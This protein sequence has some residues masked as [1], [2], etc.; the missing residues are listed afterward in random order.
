[1]DVKTPS[2]NQPLFDVFV[3]QFF[4]KV[5][6]APTLENTRSFDI[7]VAPYLPAN[8]HAT[9]LEIGVGMGHFSFYATKVRGYTNFFGV[10]VSGECVAY[11]KE[12]ITPKVE[13]TED[14]EVFLRAHPQAYDAIV[15]LDVIEHIEK[16]RQRAHLEAIHQAL[17]PGG[18]LVLRTENTAIFTGYYQH[19]MDYTHAYNFSP[20][21]LDQLLRVSGFSTIQLFGDP[22]RV[23]G[24]RSL[25]HYVLFKLWRRFLRFIYE[26]ERPGCVHPTV[27][28]KSIYAVC[29][30]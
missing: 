7:T 27:L 9:I 30:K 20:Q 4:H 13:Q 26:L 14:T 2:P 5:N 16:S 15:M 18:T 22:Q 17:R 28:T 12:R 23:T 3:S 6:E 24:A 10:D 29:K 19:T 8:R 25:I 11:V 1:M 21:S